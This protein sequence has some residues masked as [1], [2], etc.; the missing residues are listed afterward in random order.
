MN[1]A[2]SDRDGE[3]ALSLRED[4]AAGATTGNAAIV[5]G[6]TAFPTIT[7]KLQR[8]D[9]VVLG[10]LGH[11]CCV[12]KLD[13][14]GHE[15][16]FL[17]GARR[18]IERDRP[19]IVCERNQSCVPAGTQVGASD[20]EQALA[21][22]DYGYARLESG[23]VFRVPTFSSPRELDD[24]FLVPVEKMDDTLRRLNARARRPISAGATSVAP[25]APTPRGPR[26]FSGQ[27][28]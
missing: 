1:V 17:R 7:V 4:F 26:R 22:A 18:L 23:V 10:H 27:S 21:G 14:E 9:D 3:A 15:G 20:V 13:I 24:L 12:I 19:V 25:V 8:A 2:L 28:A 6:T 11:R 5:Q 16:A